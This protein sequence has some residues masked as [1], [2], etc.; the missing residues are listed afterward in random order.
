MSTISDPKLI[1]KVI[2]QCNNV[3]KQQEKISGGFADWVLQKEDL[4]KKFASLPSHE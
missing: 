4:Q 3:E 2:E 1:A